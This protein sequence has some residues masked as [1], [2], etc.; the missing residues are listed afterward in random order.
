MIL[1]TASRFR[2]KIFFDCNEI[3][4]NKLMHSHYSIA[5][6]IKID[7]KQYY[8]KHPIPQRS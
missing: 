1:I 6:Q 8:H 5:E 3:K 4:N 7:P 2:G